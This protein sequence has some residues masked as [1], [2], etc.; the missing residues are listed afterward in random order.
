MIGIGMDLR[1]GPL[2]MLRTHIGKSSRL[3]I[4]FLVIQ[5]HIESIGKANTIK[6]DEVLVNG[7]LAQNA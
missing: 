5:D 1:C 7:L 2:K 3:Y 4:L 6:R